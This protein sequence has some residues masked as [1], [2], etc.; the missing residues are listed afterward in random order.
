M[1]DKTPALVCIDS[2]EDET[3]P[4]EITVRNLKGAERTVTFDGIARTM[5]QWAE[6]GDKDREAQA[7][8]KAADEK[9]KDEKAVQ[10]DAAAGD[11]EVK[12]AAAV[13]A[14]HV[15]S[16]ARWALLMAKGWSL[17]DPY[18]LENVV[19]FEDKFPGS[20]FSLFQEYSKVIEGK[21]EKN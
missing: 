16:E 21:R 18:T 6:I 13:R 2:P 11:P 1:S 8:K 5:T 12:K 3:F 9:V 15:R 4:V 10:E 7:A 14:E 19:K 17:T 20:V